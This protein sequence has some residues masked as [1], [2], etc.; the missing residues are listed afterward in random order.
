[1]VTFPK[2]QDLKHVSLSLLKYCIQL[3]LTH[4]NMYLA[5]SVLLYV[6]TI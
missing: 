3:M 2:I 4:C 5:L 1:M 6:N